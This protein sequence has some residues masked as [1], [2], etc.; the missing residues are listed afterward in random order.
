MISFEYTDCVDD[1]DYVASLKQFNAI[2]AVLT[3]K[4]N[5]MENEKISPADIFMY[6]FSLGA[7]L[8]VDAAINFGPGRIGSIDGR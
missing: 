4:L 2:S 7:R 1:N 8:L 5:D 6:G 3:K